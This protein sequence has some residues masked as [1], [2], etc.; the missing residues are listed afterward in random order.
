ME[1]NDLLRLKKFDPTQVL[2]MRHQPTEPELKRRFHWLA[3]S[4]P[5]LYNT[6]Q[7]AQNPRAEKQLGRAKYLA[8]FIGNSPGKALFMG[9]YENHGH[10]EMSYEGYWSVPENRELKSLG[11][12]G[13]A[14]AEHRSI[15]WFDLVRLDF[16]T[17]WVGRLTV[18]WPGG[19]RA[20]SRWAS[21]NALPFD[22]LPAQSMAEPDMPEW[23]ELVLSWED[24]KSMWPS[25]RTTLSNWRGIYF[26]LDQTDGR[27]YVGSAYGEQN[28][29]GRWLNYAATGDGGNKLLRG[30]DPEKFVFSILQL[31]SPTMSETDVIRIEQTW[32]ARL[33]TVTHG[34]NDQ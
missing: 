20:W 33:S 6:Y 10:Q 34:L 4:R 3:V 2:V 29:Y 25:W 24:L 30:R 1:F 28:L 13:A 9:L 26:I 15:L 32:K 5:D 18:L 23:D 17:P 22:T 12:S 19:E 31:V 11:M 7:K 27:G 16:Y 21:E 8:S 14:G